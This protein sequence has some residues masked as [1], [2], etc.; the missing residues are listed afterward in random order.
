MGSQWAWNT[1][2]VLGQSVQPIQQTM[3]VTKF[4]PGVLTDC[5]LSSWDMSSVNGNSEKGQRSLLSSLVHLDSENNFILCIEREDWETGAM[6]H[7]RDLEAS[8]AVQH[9][10]A[11]YFGVLDSWVPKEPSRE[12]FKLLYMVMRSCSFC[13]LTWHGSQ[14]DSG[15]KFSIH[16]FF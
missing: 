14:E 4:C 11:P 9:I 10:K 2:S 16:L 12:K 15:M 3:L 13:D 7:H 1:Y 6:E 8:S 5:S